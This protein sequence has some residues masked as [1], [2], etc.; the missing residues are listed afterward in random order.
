ML[1]QQSLG[2]EVYAFKLN[3]FFGM[4]MNGHTITDTLTDRTGLGIY[5]HSEEG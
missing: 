3:A 5:L 4:L 1:P 2:T